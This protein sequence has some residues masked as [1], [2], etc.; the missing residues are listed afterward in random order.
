MGKIG[1]VITGVAL[2]IFAIGRVGSLVAP[3]SF[4]GSTA[5]AQQWDDPADDAPPQDGV[6]SQP[7]SVP[8]VAG[9]YFG[10]VE[11]SRF[12]SG[13]LGVGIDQHGKKL[14]G[15]SS[16]AFASGVGAVKG[17][18]TSKG[19]VNLRLVVPGRKKGCHLNAHGTFMNG[20]EIKGNYVVIGCGEPENGTFDMT[21]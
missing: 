19:K 11:D 1:F 2:A 4:G 18:V 7:P 3:R 21:D 13:A 12:G 16:F 20:D 15:S 5:W 14:S 9:S 6:D 8:N 17:N 10:S